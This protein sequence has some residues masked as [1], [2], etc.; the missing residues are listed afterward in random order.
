MECKGNINYGIILIF[1]IG[2]YPEW[3]VKYFHYIVE[4]LPSRH[5]NISRMECK[6]FLR[7]SSE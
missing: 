6:V 2:I 3:N 5:W 4:V 7:P 1:W